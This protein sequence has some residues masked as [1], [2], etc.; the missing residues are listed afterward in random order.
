[1]L[2]NIVVYPV[3]DENKYTDHFGN[4]LPDAVL[5]KKGSTALDL[6]QQYIQT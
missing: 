4:V 5:M 6:P 2:D 3:E 1:M